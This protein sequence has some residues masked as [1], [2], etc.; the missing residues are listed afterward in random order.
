MTNAAY[1]KIHA[2][3]ALPLPHM[4]FN[5]TNLYKTLPLLVALVVHPKSPNLRTKT[6]SRK[7]MSEAF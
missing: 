4:F 1:I 5:A 6:K 3:A 7:L 2:L